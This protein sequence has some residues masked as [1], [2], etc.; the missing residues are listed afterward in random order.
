MFSL[1]EC[2]WHLCDE[3]AADA[4]RLNV[5]VTTSADGTRLIDCGLK[6]A[7]GLEAGRRLAEICQAGLGE[8]NITAGR[9]GDAPWPLV[10]VRTDQALLACMASQYAGWQIAG[11]KFFAMGSGPMR[12]VACR[13]VRG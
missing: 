13:D 2:A 12:A 5:T 6:A 10:T 8:V 7:G 11:E 9:G 1:N 4:Q 3:L